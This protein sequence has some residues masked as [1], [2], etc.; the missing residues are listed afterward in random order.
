MT[1][2]KQN[3]EAIAEIIKHKKELWANP[4]AEEAIR[5]ITLECGL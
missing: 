2:S 5:G 3:Y 1:L 4:N